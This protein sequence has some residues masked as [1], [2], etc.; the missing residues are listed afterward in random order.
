MTY[1]AKARNGLG[2]AVLNELG[3]DL[4]EV[5]RALTRRPVVLPVHGTRH[6]GKRVSAAL[7]L[8]RKRPT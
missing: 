3:E 8:N 6:A 4:G 5:R 2:E 1:K 7:Y